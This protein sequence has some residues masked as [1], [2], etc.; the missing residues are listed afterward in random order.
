MSIIKPFLIPWASILPL[1]SSASRL[2]VH[3]QYEATHM[4]AA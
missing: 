4:R 1:K 3:A 2:E